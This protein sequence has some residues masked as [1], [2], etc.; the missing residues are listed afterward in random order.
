MA[1]TN[2]NAT[3]IPIGPAGPIGPIGP[4]GPE[5]PGSTLLNSYIDSTASIILG[6][7]L[8]TNWV[9]DDTW[10]QPTGFDNLRYTNTSGVSKEF[11]ITV[12]YSNGTS[13]ITAAT[14]GRSD[15][16]CG[17]FRATD[18]VNSL[19]DVDGAIQISFL[20]TDDPPTALQANVYNIK[21]NSNLFYK[22]TLTA[23]EAIHI[24]FKAKSGNDVGFLEKSQMFVQEL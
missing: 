4:I 14:Y 19:Y 11:L 18:L 22:V 5:G 15:V 10:Y 23:G 24:Q 12:N 8:D 21:Q 7:E 1:C 2:G 16:D 20:S 17:I 3:C 13:S 9:G 6:S